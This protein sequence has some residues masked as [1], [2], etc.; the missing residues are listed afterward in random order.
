MTGIVSTNNNSRSGGI[1]GG[2]GTVIPSTI[3]VDTINE[4]T[5]GNGVVVDNLKIKDY[6]L[7]YGSNIGLTLSSAGYVNKPNH[8]CFLARGFAGPHTTSGSWTTLTNW[9]ETF[10]IAS[11]FASGVF[12]API[13]GKYQFAFSIRVNGGNDGSDNE[14]NLVANSTSYITYFMES[15]RGP[16]Y[17]FATHT[18]T[19]DLGA[20]DTVHIEY[21]LG[22]AGQTIPTDGNSSFFSGQLIA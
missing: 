1:I 12:T 18:V 6:S 22:D 14:C 21:Y 19:V 9:S 16:A 2:S 7:M 17:A 13:T 4:K 10:D 11:N 3:D 8:P 5:S 15:T 20:S